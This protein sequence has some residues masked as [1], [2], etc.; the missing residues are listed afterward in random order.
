MGAIEDVVRV[1]VRRDR[2][3]S[4]AEIAVTSTRDAGGE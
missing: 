1:A 2:D 3:A 4:G